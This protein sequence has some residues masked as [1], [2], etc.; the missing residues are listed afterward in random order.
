MCVC[1]FNEIIYH[2][3]EDEVVVTFLEFCQKKYIVI[4]MSTTRRCEKKI[5]LYIRVIVSEF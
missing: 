4:I 2:I 1:D 5:V 3:I